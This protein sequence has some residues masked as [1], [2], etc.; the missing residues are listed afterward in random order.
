MAMNHASPDL[1]VRCDRWQRCP[2]KRCPH[3]CAH[4]HADCLG[5][6]NLTFGNERGHYTE[7]CLWW[8]IQNCEVVNEKEAS[9]TTPEVEQDETAQA[10]KE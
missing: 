4:S 1:M 3:A 9:A 6:M 2:Q 7:C 8:S 5:K 10:G